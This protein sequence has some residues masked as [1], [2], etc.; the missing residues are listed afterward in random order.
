MLN[1]NL[2][3]LKI[4]T[5][6][7][8]LA[9]CVTFVFSIFLNSTVNADTA[10]ESAPE[11]DPFALVTLDYIN[12]TLIPQVEQMIDNKIAAIP[13]KTA[14]AENPAA[15]QP[16]APTSPETTYQYQEMQNNPL[17]SFVLIE[18][19]KNQKIKAKDGTL[20]IILRPGGTAKALSAYQTQGIAN[21]TSG[22]ELLDGD[23]IP[24]NHSLI[25]PRSDDRG[26]IVT[27]VIAYMLVRGEYEIYE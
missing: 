12:K 16:P 3:D 25:I 14:P 27:S 9:F 13:A 7:V 5:I 10:A 8:A 1:K 23:D 2:K 20:E 11:A 17:A 15:T 22:G 24:M 26:I 6:L 21:I 18:L 4:K 19:T